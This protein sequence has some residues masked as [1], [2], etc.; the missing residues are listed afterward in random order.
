MV[1]RFFDLK[2]KEVINICTGQRLGFVSDVEVDME[3]GK[4]TALVVPG[5][6]RFLG[7]LG[8]EDDFVLPWECISR[9][10]DDIILIDVPPEGRVKRE[11]RPSF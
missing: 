9:I 5:P 10:S 1:T 3:S 4:I 2:Y 8:K 11:R 6:T 7:L